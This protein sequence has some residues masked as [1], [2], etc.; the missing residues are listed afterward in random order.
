M[1]LY[2]IKMIIDG[3]GVPYQIFGSSDYDYEPVIHYGLLNAFLFT[4]LFFGLPILVCIIVRIKIHKSAY[5]KKLNDYNQ[6][7]ELSEDVMI[8][9]EQMKEYMKTQ[10]IDDIFNDEKSNESN[11][12]NQL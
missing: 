7:K 5:N 9:K 4:F 3:I 1:N 8:L 11:Q 10:N 2:N 6:E 12:S